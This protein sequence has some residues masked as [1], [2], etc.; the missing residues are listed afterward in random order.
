[1]NY[2]QA[3]RMSELVDLGDSLQRPDSGHL[4]QASTDEEKGEDRWGS[5][6]WQHVGCGCI[7]LLSLVASS[8]ASA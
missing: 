7:I 2:F 5:G 6:I 4:R 8:F 1:M 3:K